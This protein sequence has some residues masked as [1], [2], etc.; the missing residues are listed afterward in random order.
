VGEEEVS[1]VI[2]EE[3]LGPEEIRAVNEDAR[4]D[5]MTEKALL[6]LIRE[7]PGIK[8]HEIVIACGE[9]VPRYVATRQY[10]SKIL[11]RLKKRGAL[12]SQGTRWYLPEML[13]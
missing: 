12:R 5:A 8:A 13:P 6:S 4:I 3:P 7:S 1:A 2:G 9:R 11:N 10:R